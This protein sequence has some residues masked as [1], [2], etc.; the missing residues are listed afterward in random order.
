MSI[1]F[2]LFTVAALVLAAA[3]D[4]NDAVG[5]E[6]EFR[7]AQAP[8][9]ALTALNWNIY[10]GAD[11]DAVIQA[12]ASP[13]PDDDLPALLAAIQTLQATAFPLRAVAIV[14]EIARQRPHVVGLQ[15]VFLIDIDLTGL[16]LPVVI[17]LDFLAIL[18]A[19]IVAR[20]LPYVVAAV[21]NN[22]DAEPF[23]GIRVLDRDVIL[24]DQSRTTVLSST[25]ANFAANIGVVAPGVNLI[26]GWVAIDA[27][28][29]GIDY[30]I[31]NTH[32]EAGRGEALSG[33]RALQAMELAA[34]AGAA[35]RV[36]LLGDLNDPPGSPMYD[37][38]LGAG[39]VDLWAALRPGVAGLTCCHDT[40]LSNMLATFDQRIDYV[41]TRGI[42]HPRA[43][44]LGR[45]EIIGN[46]PSDRLD[47]PFHRIWPSDHAGLVANLVVPP[48]Q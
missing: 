39:F 17:D 9:H 1:R 32:L 5:P 46:L 15:E 47:G 31:I 28:V 48:V 36:V 23:P 6:P 35:P 10:V 40:D 45:I 34:V 29:N 41:M 27:E 3:C 19:H 26:R 24:V 2:R 11:V 44:V 4:R 38:L 25:G 16:G 7:A 37:V 12:L 20:G 14:D 22:V 42:G 43:G 18:Q 33:L 8:A 13:D 21:V 30:R